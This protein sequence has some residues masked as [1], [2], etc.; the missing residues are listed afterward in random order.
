[1]E[2]HLAILACEKVLPKGPMVPTALPLF[3]EGKLEPPLKSAGKDS[4]L[5]NHF[6]YLEVSQL[7]ESVT[8]KVNDCQP[9]STSTN[10]IVL[11]ASR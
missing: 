1:M 4:P 11:K 7:E 6:R 2:T 3:W 9:T 8:T 5:T 10:L